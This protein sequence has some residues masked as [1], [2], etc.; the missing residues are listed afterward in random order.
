MYWTV[1]EYYFFHKKSKLNVI[2]FACEQFPFTLYLLTNLSVTYEESN[3][4]LTAGSTNE[5]SCE[6]HWAH[7]PKSALQH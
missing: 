4:S 6:L 3:K 5:T 7:Y 2:V 1:S